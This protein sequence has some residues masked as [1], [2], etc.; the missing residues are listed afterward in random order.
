MSNQFR[1]KLLVSTLLA[2]VAAMATPAQAK[3][4]PQT[5]NNPE[6]SPDA[7]GNA[8]V[9]GQAGA[10]NAAATTTNDVVVTGTLIR[11]PNLTASSPV[12]VVNEAEITL[13]APTTAE[14]AIRSLPGVVP[15]IGTQ[16]NNGANGT[17]SID[18]R[19]LGVQRNIVLLDGNRLVPTLANGA[20]DL[21]AIPLALLQRI[22]VLTGGAST[23]YGA[24]A[25]S[26]VVNFITRR[27]FTGLDARASYGLTERGDGQSRR[28]DVTV[29][30]N[31]ADDRGNAVLSMGYTKADPV[32]QVRPYALFGIS[33]TT[34]VASGA[35]A[36]SV[37]TAIAFNNGDFL[38]VS[39]DAGSLIPQYQGF[40]FNPYNIFQTPIDRK[41]IYAAARYDVA[42]GI[43]FYARG[44]FT[45]NSIQQII[46]PSGV[47]GLGLTVPGNN[48]YL[49]ANVRNQLCT[50][51]G[52]ALGATC[53]TNPA[54]P[55]PGVYR[56]AVE[57]G[58]RIALF[59]NN[60]YDGRVGMRF[61][62]T[63]STTLDVN[64]S[65]GRSEQIQNQSGYVLNSR[66]QQALNANNTT[67][68]TVT[69][70]ACV[71]VNLF[72]PAG[73]ITPAQANF[74]NGGSTT[75]ILT[76]L[77]QGRAVFSGDAGISIPY[78]DNPISF[79][80]GGE[81]RQYTYNR[82]PD[83]TAQ[84]PSELGGAGGA[85]LPF[86]GGYEV[87]EGFGELIVPI[88]SDKPFFHELTLE[89][90]VRYS[91]YKINAAN[92]P[93]FNTTTYKAGVTFEPVESV[94]FRANYQRASRAPNIAELFAPTVTGLTNL[95]TEPC[96]GSSRATITN[97]A[98]A[99]VANP[100]F[101]AGLVAGQNLRAICLAQGA[102]AASI[103][104][105][106]ANANGSTS[107]VGI[108]N[109]SAGQAN[110]TTGGD[111]NTRPEKADTFTAGIVVTPRGILPGFNFS[112]D[113]YD[114]V[115]RNAITTPTPGDIIGAC[116]TNITAASA[117]S[118]ACTGIRRNPVNGA[119]SGPSSTTFGLPAP[120]TNLGRLRS[121][122]VDLTANYQHNFGTVGL[123][124]NFVGNYTR[125]LEFQAISQADPRF[126]I[127]VNRNCV[128]YYSA[129]CGPSLG[130]IQP[131]Y[132]FQQRTTLS[133]EGASLSVLWRY[134]NPVDYEGTAADFAARGFTA[135]N[136]F[137]Y[138]SATATAARATITNGAGASSELAGQR[139]NFNHIRAYHYFDAA[140]QFDVARQ[141]Q[142]TF[143]VKNLFDV[144]PPIVGGQ[145]GTT[146]ANSGNTFP[147]TYDPLGRAYSAGVRVKF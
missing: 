143:T 42:D 48:P 34:G 95:T 36:T 58:P 23:T 99:T 13:R 73:S 119:L 46:A 110:V 45:N 21:N 20:V 139:A 56:R 86:R 52:I 60:L 33:S 100:T 2:G 24:D 9:A 75:R 120:T 18:L 62:V 53:N 28:I 49:N 116:F 104:V 30:A 102:S 114:I 147:S 142:L 67:T 96:V 136:R 105:L 108:P 133:V 70:N 63:P 55:L 146:T 66:V 127:G 79:A 98:G 90:G 27:D 83:V 115:I 11:N 145:A 112:V 135:A 47:F 111:V 8:A 128:G 35:S 14:E 10:D 131:K 97:A 92:N 44:L 61:D 68:C 81:Y 113:Y 22:D 80:I 103:D 37:P 16:V 89:G 3:Q 134:L 106:S 26:G 91:H 54:I 15:G 126:A 29:G 122:G 137:L 72:G 130:Q 76:E 118:V 140:L 121:S 82:M 101:N 93:S 141:F 129:N 38:Q 7:A 12:N 25:V 59:E 32:Y 78:A 1:N 85:I 31:F 84:S 19:G 40:N 5:S 124:L 65:Y 6:Q 77:K 4:Q 74:L 17:N 88:A 109:P 87:S 41:S 51:N 71:P 125:K 57:L 132:S 50:E 43:E 144:E 138:N 64:G 123:N 69:T 107:A 117:S 39:P 94:R